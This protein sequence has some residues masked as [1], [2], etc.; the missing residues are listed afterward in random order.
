MNPASVISSKN[1]FE[2]AI[3]LFQDIRNST[4]VLLFSLNTSVM[5]VT[6]SG[7]EL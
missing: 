2:E 1:T 6:R 4:I 5:V 7:Y 3:L